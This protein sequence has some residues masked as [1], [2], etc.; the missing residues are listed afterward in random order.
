MIA[1]LS[2]PRILRQSLLLTYNPTL[3]DEVIPMRLY[4]SAFVLLLISVSLPPQ[5]EKPLQFKGTVTTEDGRPIQRAYVLVH[6]YALGGQGQSSENWETRTLS[7]GSFTILLEPRCYDIF[8][9]SG[10]ML[11]FS[12]RV[13]VQPSSFRIKLRPDPHPHLPIS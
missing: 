7:D 10:A 13:C 5:N 12:Q 11:P 8:V 9:S 4:T 1:S 3:A 6:D 2:V